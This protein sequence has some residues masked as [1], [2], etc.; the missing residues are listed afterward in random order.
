MHTQA[1]FEL[2]QEAERLLQLALQN[3]NSL[4]ATSFTTQ[5]DENDQ[6]KAQVGSVASSKFCPRT[7]QEQQAM[8]QNELRKITQNEMVLA[9]VGTVKAGKSTTINAI[10][11]TEV[12]PNR[13]RPMT[14]LPTLIRH[15]PGQREPVL[16]FPYVQPIDKLMQTLQLR[17][18][19]TDRATLGRHLEIDRDMA[20][21]LTRI[22]EGE[23]FAK[24]Y[25]G[26]Q[27][28]FH[29]LKSLNDLVRLSKALDVA[30][31]F[32]AYAAIEHVPV[33]EV[34]FVHLAGINEGHGQLTLLDTPGP[35]EAGQP[36]L[37]KML[38]EQ[39]AQASAVLAVLD[40]TQLKSVSD[41]DV[42]KAILGTGSCVPLY[43]LVNKFDQKDRNGDDEEQVKALISGTLMKGMI[44]P[45]HVFPVSSMWG[46]LAN[47]ARH[48]M[49][50]HTKLPDPDEHRWVQ[51]FADAA[52]GRRWQRDDL[53]DSAVVH[54]A[55]ELLWQDSQFAEPI[56]KVLHAAHA[57]ASMYALR[58][59]C[60]KLLN[61]TQSAEEYLN[62]RSQGLRIAS[63]Q[64]Q[65]NI[66]AIEEDINQAAASQQSAGE[67]ARSN[68]DQAVDAMEDFIRRYQQQINANVADY[69]QNGTVPE[70]LTR[71][72]MAFGTRRGVDFDA[73]YD[74]LSFDD[75]QSAQ[76]A[77]HRIRAS[78]EIILTA[79][80][81]KMTEE[82]MHLFSYL[83]IELA[84]TLRNTLKPIESRVAQGL[85]QAGFRTNITLPV[86][87]VGLLNFNA[88]KAFNELIEEQDIPVARLRR[89]A[90]MRGTVARWL[91]SDEWGWEGYT[92]MQSR[93]VISLPDVQH[94]L[95]EHVANFLL[96]LNQTM[97][98][99]IENAV[100]EGMS[101][102]FVDFSQALDAIR[103][104]L[105]QSLLARQQN[106]DAVMSLRHQLQ[107][108]VRTTRY[109]HEDTRLLRDDIQTLFTVEQQ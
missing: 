103:L 73:R 104:N 78:C 67:V 3:L 51:D 42:R 86:F 71:Q 10:I 99:Q 15:T 105:Q 107:Q 44:E 82:L 16:H 66:T 109:I 5:P 33:I 25:L 54:Q 72:A 36:H 49:A 91:N 18:Q 31:P 1:I 7:I 98:A 24:H 62:F 26:A 90:G 41:E 20:A 68:V 97:A 23:S 38:R 2:S 61:Y 37:Q 93:Y 81:E 52:L 70:K 39:L 106:E 63:E 57:N 22:T 85:A 56:K 102:F 58:S 80:Q 94:K 75:E 11:G 43:A 48:E 83:E 89:P 28:I 100:S 95:C 88:N 29:C 13:N 27:P 108:C 59:A 19:Q 84:D 9:I 47:R 14:A 77:L 46:Y 17:L 101:A 21:L 64:L 79:A 12:L 30:F 8:L 32:K 55:A 6:G 65:Q 40:Y 35:N 69:F 53:A 96:Q 92:V 50:L 60:Q 87:H 4:K 45:S 34:E 76:I 74:T